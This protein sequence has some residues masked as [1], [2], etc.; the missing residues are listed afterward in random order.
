MT[1]ESYSQP[2]VLIAGI[3]GASLGTE[4]AKCLN[5]TARYEVFG[6]DI[7]R[8]AYGHYSGFKET[9][10]VDHSSYVDSVL[11]LCKKRRFGF[12]IPGADEP[13]R[14]LGRAQPRFAEDGIQ[15][16]CNSPQ[17]VE[18]FSNKATT[19]ET[20]TALHLPIPRTVLVKS[21][22][23]VQAMSFPCVVK[24]ATMTGGSSLVFH[25]SD[26]DEALLYVRFITKEGRPVILQEFLPER[27][28][29]FTVGVLSYPDGSLATS[30]ALRRMFEHKL[31]V[32]NTSNFGVISTGYSEGLID[33]FPEVCAQAEAISRAVGSTGP[34]NIQGRIRNGTFVPFEINPRFSASVYLRAMAGVNE[35]DIYLQH[36]ISGEVQPPQRLRVGYYL[37]SLTEL[38]VDPASVKQL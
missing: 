32:L 4:L 1:P 3:A 26:A 35:V 19:F 25:A 30:I 6:C 12:V 8:F 17:L 11:D 33:V 36:L 2:Q 24:P 28:G 15:V 7:S 22:K 14:L 34:L 37:R 20:L 10:L 9:F 27:D 23:D 21:E 31:A 5:L 13:S 16:V 29:E 38:F 18:R